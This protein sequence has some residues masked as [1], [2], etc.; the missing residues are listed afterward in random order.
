MKRFHSWTAFS[1][2]TRAALFACVGLALSFGLP[3]TA[4]ATCVGG[5]TGTGTVEP[6][7]ECDDGAAGGNGTNGSANSCCTTSCTLSSKIP[8]LY[9]GDLPDTTVYRLGSMHA[10]AIGTTS[11]TVAG[12]DHCWVKWFSSI[13]E[14]PIIG[15]NMFRLKN[16][17]FEQVGQ[18]WLKHGFTALQGSVCNPTCTQAPNGSHLGV[19]C[20]DPYTATL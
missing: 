4:H 18:A 16:G 15:Q 14:H 10:F 3:R 17:R 6:G 2:M 5:G 11:C 7:E 8:D 1:S 19:G 20:S 9:V 13:A 12:T